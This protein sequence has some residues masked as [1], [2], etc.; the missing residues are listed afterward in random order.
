[1]LIWLYL[2][3]G[4]TGVYISKAK[5]NVIS[6]LR[7]FQVFDFQSTSG[8]STQ[9]FLVSMKSSPC[10][11]VQ[12]IVEHL[13]AIPCCVVLR[14]RCRGDSITMKLDLSIQ[15]LELLLRFNWL[16]GLLLTNLPW[17]SSA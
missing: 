9:G 7:P 12:E 13:V 16:T 11:T 15:F 5:V 17:V 3:I 10:K 2:D 4:L 8:P 6:R 1:M 14:A